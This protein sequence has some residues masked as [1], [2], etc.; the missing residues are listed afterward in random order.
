MWQKATAI[1]EMKNRETSGSFM[2]GLGRITAATWDEW[3]N[4]GKIMHSKQWKEEY[5]R[6]SQTPAK[7]MFSHAW[8]A[9][10]NLKNQ[11]KQ[12]QY[13]AAGIAFVQNLF[14]EKYEPMESSVKW[15]PMPGSNSDE[16]EGLITGMIKSFTGE[17]NRDEIAY[18]LSDY[19]SLKES[20]NSAVDS[21]YG[22]YNDDVMDS[23]NGFVS[24]LQGLDQNVT[25]CPDKTKTQ[26]A[27]M[28]AKLE[29][30]TPFDKKKIIGALADNKNHVEL[31]LSEMKMYQAGQEY[32]NL[33]ESFA[34]I[35]LTLATN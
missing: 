3:R 32:A 14:P 13:E 29:R 11:M 33:G 17:E 25:N 4:F 12:G 19:D 22:R 8:M 15:D 27:E 9:Y 21:L 28:Q 1:F 23:M 30:H 35:F 2:T 7:E 18:C 5:H 26:V 24:V 10:A 31:K 20:V 16:L 34:D 6:L